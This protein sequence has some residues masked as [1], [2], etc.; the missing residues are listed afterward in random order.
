MTDYGQ[1]YGKGL[2]IENIASFKL[3]D[4]IKV[5]FSETIVDGNKI[6]YNFTVKTFM[7]I[8]YDNINRR[9]TRQWVSPAS[10][11]QIVFNIYMQ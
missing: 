7:I 11:S 6:N 4:F 3:Y 2:E 1:S 8:L 5:D 10:D 9:R